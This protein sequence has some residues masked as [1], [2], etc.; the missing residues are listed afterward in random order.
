MDI[1]LF[2]ETGCP[3]QKIDADMRYQYSDSVH[4]I[5]QNS[6]TQNFKLETL[7][8]SY[9]VIPENSM[10]AIAIKPV[11]IMRMPNPWRPSGTSA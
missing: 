1:C 3:F 6:T 10:K 8:H 11:T 5:R 9:K 2:I 4:I 7:D